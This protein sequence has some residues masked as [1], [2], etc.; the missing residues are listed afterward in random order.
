MQNVFIKNIRQLKGD[1]RSF[2]CKNFSLIKG[3]QPLPLDPP[4]SSVPQSLNANQHNG[5]DNF[6]EIENW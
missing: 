6:E 5:I 3:F 1:I 4:V 2:R